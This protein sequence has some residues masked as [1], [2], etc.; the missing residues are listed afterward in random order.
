M[1]KAD[2][3][4]RIHQQVGLSEHEAGELLDWILALFKSTLQNGEEIAITGFGKFTVRSKHARTGRNPRTRE[5]TT[6]SARRVV[7]FH[8]S[9]LLK[10]EVNV[11]GQKFQEAS[12]QISRADGSLVERTIEHGSIDR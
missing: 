3:A 2:I 4:R 5:E 12:P 7:T 1:T 6:I 11:A 8:A 9:P 10:A